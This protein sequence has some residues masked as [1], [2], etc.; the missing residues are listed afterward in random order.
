MGCSFVFAGELCYDILN[1]A[2]S[3]RL[4]VSQFSIAGSRPICWLARPG[5]LR[6]GGCTEGRVAAVPTG[7][8]CRNPGNAYLILSENR[9]HRMIMPR[10]NGR[11]EDGPKSRFIGWG[12]ASAR[13]MLLMSPDDTTLNLS[14][15]NRQ[16][17]REQSHSFY[18]RFF[19]GHFSM[20]AVPCRESTDFRADASLKGDP[21]PGVP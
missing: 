15:R 2:G 6:H 17:V 7:K 5:D 14:G 13:L 10:Q 20:P 21:V 8:S 19:V 18:N 16:P 4:W 9:E 1:P 12:S 3:D 11:H